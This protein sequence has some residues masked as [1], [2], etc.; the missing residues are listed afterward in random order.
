M[1]VH[2]SRCSSCYNWMK[3]CH[4]PKP[5]NPMHLNRSYTCDSYIPC[6]PESED[7]ITKEDLE[8]V[9]KFYTESELLKMNDGSVNVNIRPGEKA[10][11]DEAL[12][13]LIERYKNLLIASAENETVKDIVV[14]A[15]KLESI[16]SLKNHIKI[17]KH[18]TR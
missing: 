17:S 1:L 2:T 7:R 4:Y 16:E 12:T 9:Q 18:F 3:K 8:I 13:L 10:L 5:Y 6:R 11:L 14:Y 15:K